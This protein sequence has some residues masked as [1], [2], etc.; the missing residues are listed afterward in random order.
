MECR[1]AAMPFAIHS[2]HAIVT[3]V[4]REKLFTCALPRRYSI[5]YL[6]AGACY[7]ACENPVDAL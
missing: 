1:S 6:V 5:S 7:V 4:D 2:R 3:L